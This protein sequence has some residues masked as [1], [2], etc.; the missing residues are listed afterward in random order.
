M[1]VGEE[2][3]D[4]VGD[5]TSGGGDVGEFNGESA[6]ALVLSAALAVTNAGRP[7]AGS[8]CLPEGEEASLLA[9]NANARSRS[10]ASTFRNNSFSSSSSVGN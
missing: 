6:G 7:P 5:E 3:S 10:S 9:A 2:V 4:P 8:E 1:P